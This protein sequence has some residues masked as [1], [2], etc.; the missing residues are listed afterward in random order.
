MISSTYNKNNA[1][2]KNKFSI[3]NGSQFPLLTTPTPQKK[4]KILNLISYFK[5][6]TAVCVK[7]SKIGS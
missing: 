6:K 7:I 3:G 1:N 2:F 4:L 5:K